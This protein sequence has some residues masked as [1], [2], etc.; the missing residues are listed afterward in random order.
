M[1]SDA[2]IRKVRR[3]E[4]MGMGGKTNLCIPEEREE[5]DWGSVP[6]VCVVGIRVLGKRVC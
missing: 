6:S 2:G 3:N 1:S 5:Q 4:R